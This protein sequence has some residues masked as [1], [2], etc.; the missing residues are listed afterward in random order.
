MTRKNALQVT[1]HRCQPSPTSFRLHSEIRNTAPL[2]K[3]AIPRRRCS[4]LSVPRCDR[5][6]GM[7]TLQREVETVQYHVELDARH[8]K[9]ERSIEWLSCLEYTMARKMDEPMYSEALP[10]SRR[11]RILGDKS[12]HCCLETLYV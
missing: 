11:C 3:D 5:Q 1:V 4:P 7:Q 6:K 2:Q 8:L 12:G 9:L 10:N